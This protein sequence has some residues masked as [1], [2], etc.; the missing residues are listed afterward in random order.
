MKFD[1][2]K[3]YRLAFWIS[4]LGIIAFVI[5]FGFSQS[6]GVQRIINAFYLIVLVIG[7]S[8][9]VIR[10][11]VRKMKLSSPVR[12]SDLFI[13]I[14]ILG[15][16]YIH[17]IA[18]GVHHLHYILYDDNWIKFAIILIF[19]REFSELNVHFK[20]TYLNP[21]QLFLVSFI[22]MIILGSFLLMLPKATHSGIG[23]LDALFTSTSAVCVTGL[24]VVDT[25]TYFTT[26]GQSVILFL[27]QIGGIGILTITSYFSYFFK[28]GTTYE[29]QLILSDMTS[30]Q[31]I[32]EVFS[33]LKH[34]II[35]TFGAEFLAAIAIY[36][37]IAGQTWDSQTE[38]IFFSAFHAISAFCNAGFSTLS[39]SIYDEGFRFN[40][41]FQLL[42]VMTFVIGGLGFPIMVNLKNFIKLKLGILLS[43]KKKVRIHRPWVLTLNSRITLITTFSL[44]LIGFIIFYLLEF[45]NTLA[46]HHSWGKMVS[47][48]FNAATPR[49]AGFNNI[50]MAQMHHSTILMIILLMWIGASPASTGGGIKTS[51]FAIATLN[52]LSLAKGKSDIEV[53]RRRISPISVK[54]AFAIIALS[55]VV[56]G[57]GI[58]F[59]SI[60]EGDV[61]ILSIIFE[62][63]SAY[64]TVGLSLG[65][66]GGLTGLSKLVIIGIMFI[67]RVSM[68]TVMIAIFSKTRPMN[69][70]YPTEEITL[71]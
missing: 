66:T 21:A 26:F 54:R 4:F 61:P 13:L 9:L 45:N 49:T 68:L 25:G 23:F 67:G 5:D 43:S 50:D 16:L 8:S 33:T 71:N 38:H 62:C 70:I 40:Y 6:P 24:I 17:F 34:V 51:T 55:F 15:V 35:I 29:N 63:V 37:S 36:F 3:L 7:L 46:D 14:I 30:S 18:E 60:F 65:I 27:I 52:V 41:M 42:L 20:R 39:N 58:W 57:A 11:L 48:L 56:I 69:Y 32:G 22:S 64:S 19:I 44:T 31:K 59:V 47:A 12:V 1:Y 2:D 10:N 53:F 28:G